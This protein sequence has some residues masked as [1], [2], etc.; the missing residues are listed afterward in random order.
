MFFVVHE[1]HL[2]ESDDC[3]VRSLFLDE[4]LD[5]LEKGFDEVVLR[6][7]ITREW[8]QVVLLKHDESD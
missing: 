5:A 6:E 2:R 1:K 7:A 8:R 4:E 3:F